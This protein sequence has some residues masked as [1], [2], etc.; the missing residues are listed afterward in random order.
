MLHNIHTYYIVYIQFNIVC[1]SNLL[2]LNKY[3]IKYHTLYFWNK[4]VIIKFLLTFWILNHKISH[5]LTTSE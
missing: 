5:F 2:K 1:S 4:I 3:N